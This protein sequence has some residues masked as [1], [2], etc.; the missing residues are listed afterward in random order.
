MSNVNDE[1]NVES[2]CD[3]AKSESNP[4]NTSEI[5]FTFFYSNLFM[6]LMCEN[7]VERS[8]ISVVYSRVIYPIVTSTKL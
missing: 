6:F 1:K 2:E 5:E 8:A 3:F 4:D 7:V